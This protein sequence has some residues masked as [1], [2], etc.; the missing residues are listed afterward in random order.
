[1]R[2]RKRAVIR[3]LVRVGHGYRLLGRICRYRYSAHIN[4]DTFSL[5]K[6]IKSNMNYNKLSYLIHIRSYS[7]II[8]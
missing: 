6:F 8:M 2:N 4:S 5:L 7:K 3:G 1:M